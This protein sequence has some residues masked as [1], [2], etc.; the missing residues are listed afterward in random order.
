M[1]VVVG[2]GGAMIWTYEPRCGVL[3]SGV[4][5]SMAGPSPIRAGSLTEGIVAVSGT[6]VVVAVESGTVGAARARVQRRPRPMCK[7]RRGPTSNE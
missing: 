1:V 5:L 2:R 3:G 7:Q 6:V 4:S